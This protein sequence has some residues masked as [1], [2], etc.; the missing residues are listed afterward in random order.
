MLV[1]RALAPGKGN[2][3]ENVAGTRKPKA[4]INYAVEKI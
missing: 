2:E 3:K 4:L 1:A